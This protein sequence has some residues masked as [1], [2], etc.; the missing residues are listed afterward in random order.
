[1]CV[2]VCKMTQ[3]VLVYTASGIL[4]E[5]PEGCVRNHL[6]LETRAS[7]LGELEPN[8][9]IWCDNNTYGVWGHRITRMVAYC[10]E[11]SS[12]SCHWPLFLTGRFELESFSD[13]QFCKRYNCRYRRLIYVRKSTISNNI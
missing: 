1:M 3:G 13:W 10:L 7:E 4:N 5:F 6:P 12:G 9:W 8:V 2:V 11:S